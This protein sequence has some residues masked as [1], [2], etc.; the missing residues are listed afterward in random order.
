MSHNG[1]AEMRAA[2]GMARMLTEFKLRVNRSL[3]VVNS[4]YK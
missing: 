4:L 3:V 1:A 2:G